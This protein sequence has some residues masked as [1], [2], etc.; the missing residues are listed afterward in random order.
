MS[1][2]RGG[3]LRAGGKQPGVSEYT[4]VSTGSS[5]SLHCVPTPCPFL[6]QPR[7]GGQ[8]W[9]GPEDT[10]WSLCT[11]HTARP[12]GGANTMR[13]VQST[14]GTPLLSDDLGHLQLSLGERPSRARLPERGPQ[15]RKGRPRRPSKQTSQK[16]SQ[17]TRGTLPCSPP[18]HTSGTSSQT[19]RLHPRPSSLLLFSLP[20]EESAEVK[21]SP[22]WPRVKVYS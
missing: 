19:R 12:N 16:H 1:T 13:C 4:Q 7:G 22:E 5:W 14:Q 8:L 2:G 6:P 9:S 10:D 3:V 15:G 21:I 11:A 18:S 17:S 20:V